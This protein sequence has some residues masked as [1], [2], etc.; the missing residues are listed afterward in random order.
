ML[1][2]IDNFGAI[3]ASPLDVVRLVASSMGI[4]GVDVEPTGHGS[5]VVINSSM[6]PVRGKNLE[7]ACESFLNQ[8]FDK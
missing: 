8:A 5:G 4:S 1:V 3:G 6:G 2:V 7:T